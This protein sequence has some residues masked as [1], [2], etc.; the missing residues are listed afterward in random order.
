MRLEVRLFA[1]ASG[2][3]QPRDF[4][5]SLP[6]ADS[7]CI[8]AD[9]VAVAEKGRQAPV[10]V[11]SIKGVRGLLEIRTLGFRTFFTIRD[12]TLWVLHA[13]RKQDQWHGIEVARARMR[14]LEI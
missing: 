11:K 1:T 8:A 3:S 14:V 13:C 9:I 7:A 4:L 2:R 10:S 5:A 12:G 6:P